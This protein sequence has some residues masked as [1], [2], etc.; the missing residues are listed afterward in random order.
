M[1]SPKSGSRL[2]GAPVVLIR[3]P[4]VMQWWRID[5]GALIGPMFLGRM[6][7]GRRLP[8]PDCVRSRG[9]CSQDLPI[10]ASALARPGVDDFL[11]VGMLLQQLLGVVTAFRFP[12]HGRAPSN[13]RRNGGVPPV[14]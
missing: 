6:F 5:V 9:L 11:V 7:L 2:T 10:I 4:I 1:P 13:S 3:M 14:E 8:R 12:W